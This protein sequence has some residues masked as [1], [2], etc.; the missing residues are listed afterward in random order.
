MTGAMKDGLSSVGVSSVVGVSSIVGLSPNKD[1]L[2][3]NVGLS[4]VGRGPDATGFGVG[5]LVGFGVGDVA[6]FGV[7]EVTGLGVGEVTG[8]G[9]GEL[10]GF[11]VGELV[12]F[13]VGEFPAGRVSIGD[14][15]GAG[16]PLP[17]HP[18]RSPLSSF[19]MVF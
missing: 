17:P 6:G 1:G 15:T 9:V 5:E 4:S 12:G 13:G 2:K 19:F 16:L 10:A 18:D 14:E 8:F 3:S 11:G 7:G